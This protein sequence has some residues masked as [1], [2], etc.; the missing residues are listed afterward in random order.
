[1]NNHLPL[2]NQTFQMIKRKE[3]MFRIDAYLKSQNVTEEEIEQIK[4]KASNQYKTYV[5][6]TLVKRN[7]TCFY[8][9]IA[10]TVLSFLLFFFFI[11]NQIIIENITL[12][13]VFGALLLSFSI[14]FTYAFYNSWN[15]NDFPENPTLDF[16][17]GNFM[18]F[19][20]PLALIPSVIFFFLIQYRIEK[21]AKDSLIATKVETTGIVTDGTFYESTSLKGRKSNDAEI[22][23]KF[24][25]KDKKTIKK[26]IEISPNEFNSYYK[27][28]EVNLI[29]SSENPNNFMLLNSFSDL[30]E[31]YKT[32]ER[33]ID[34]E[35]L[36]YYLD[37]NNA[38]ILELLNTI[39]YGWKF[40]KIQNAFINKSRES[41]FIKENGVILFFPKKGYDMYLEKKLRD[42]SYKRRTSD[43]DY[44]IVSYENGSFIVDKL[45]IREGNE[46]ML[47]FKVYKTQL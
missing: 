11:P 27:G 24:K 47:F 41:V 9:G 46:V 30:K 15:E 40:D 33:D 2:I 4:E 28:K 43:D 45:S 5:I 38:Q 25:T 44:V 42:N 6:E 22:T 7:K 34:F 13:A 3:L 36:T 19:F 1:M 10:A 12:T 23:V 8:I 37:R 17:L 35:D 31:I 26:T 20:I 16:D 18:S 39:S 21:V 32:Q 29:Y 14:Y